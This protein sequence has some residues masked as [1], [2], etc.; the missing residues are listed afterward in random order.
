MRKLIIP[1]AAI[2]FCS[3]SC[4]TLEPTAKDKPVDPVDAKVAGLLARMV[5]EEKVGQMTQ[6]T[7]EAV[8]GK[9]ENGYLKLDER[10]CVTPSWSTRSARY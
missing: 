4:A 6:V 1:A 2:L 3:L 10:S 7:L 9:S 5:L 8:A